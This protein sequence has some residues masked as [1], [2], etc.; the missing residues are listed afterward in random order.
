[1][2][3]SQ[4]ATKLKVDDFT[5]VIRYSRCIVAFWKRHVPNCIDYL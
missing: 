4:L 2:K 3:K 1:V 5:W